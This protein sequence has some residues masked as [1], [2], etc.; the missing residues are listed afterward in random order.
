M[1]K[2]E[3]SPPYILGPENILY[4]SWA[5]KAMVLNCEPSKERMLLSFKLLSDPESKNESTGR[6]KKKE[7][8]HQCWVLVD[9]NVVG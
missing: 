6:G 7:E 4:T 2:H 5:V 9:V 8:R 1:P 3:I